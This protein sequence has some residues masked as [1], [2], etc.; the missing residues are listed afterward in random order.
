LRKA[1]LFPDVQSRVV[2]YLEDANPVHDIERIIQRA[3]MNRHD[4]DGDADGFL[5]NFRHSTGDRKKLLLSTILALVGACPVERSV[6][7]RVSGYTGHAVWTDLTLCAIKI[8][9]EHVGSHSEDR[10]FLTTLLRSHPGTG[11]WQGNLL[12][13]LMGLHALFTF[14]PDGFLL[15]RGAAALASRLNPDGG[16]PFIAGQDVWVSALAGSALVDSGAAPAAAERLGDFIAAR[17]LPDGGWGFDRGTTQSDVDDTSRCVSFLQ[18]LSPAEYAGELRRGRGYLTAMAG[19]DG[20][21]P[22]YVRG[23]PSEVDLT[24]GSVLALMDDS[25][26]AVPVLA[27]AADFLLSA[28][29]ADGAFDPSWTRSQASVISHVIQALHE[30]KRVGV[31]PTRNPR[32]RRA[33]GNSVNFLVQ[34]QNG[35]GG[36][37]HRG[38]DISDAISTAHAVSALA[39]C[40]RPRLLVRAIGVLHS[41]DGDVPAAPPDQV[42]PRP[43]PYDFPVLAEIHVLNALNRMV[44]AS[45]S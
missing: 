12:A 27:R 8:I 18:S 9:N 2:H 23:D 20:G 22:T 19:A 30:L 11:V 28:Q 36:W 39:G 7:R 1:R 38:G 21:F 25:P 45:R 31:G 34:Q 6:G 17:Q 40:V 24:A 43:I 10:L 26:T 15:R 16:V 14:A 33:I 42:G 44:E 5:R 4:R 41:Q 13:H 29:H 3:A 35:G 37:G 32:I